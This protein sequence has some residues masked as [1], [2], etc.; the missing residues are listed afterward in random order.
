MGGALVGMPFMYAAGGMLIMRNLSPDFARLQ[1]KQR[2]LE[3]QYRQGQS[4]VQASAE[5]VA[6]F[7]GHEFEEEELK[8]DHR[9]HHNNPSQQP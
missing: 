2:A 5:A 9:T 1:K 7:G 4:R 3:G 6:L 8:G